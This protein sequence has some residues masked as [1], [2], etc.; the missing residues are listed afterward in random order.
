MTPTAAQVRVLRWL[1]A[2]PGR[3]VFEYYDARGSY[4]SG[5]RLVSRRGAAGR[6]HWMMV[7]AGLIEGDRYTPVLTDAGRAAI[8]V[9]P[10]RM[11]SD[12]PGLGAS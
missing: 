6:M 10:V 7:E 8:G 5:L 4:V 11:P 1:H 9:T 2:H 3:D 12:N